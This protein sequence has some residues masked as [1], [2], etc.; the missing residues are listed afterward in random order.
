MFISESHVIRILVLIRMTHSEK[1]MDHLNY[2]YQDTEKAYEKS[3]LSPQICEL[4]NLNAIAYLIVYQS[5]D[6]KENK[7]AFFSLDNIEV[8]A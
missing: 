4:R 2:L 1:A 6:R 7:G 3:K 5:M 8:K